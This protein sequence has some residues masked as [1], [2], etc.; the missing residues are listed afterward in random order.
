MAQMGGREI[1]FRAADAVP[2]DHVRKSE[3]LKLKSGS[4]KR[5]STSKLLRV[6]GVKDISRR[7]W[8]MKL[9]G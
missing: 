6:I 1:G 5:I 7:A 8:E 3:G 4:G 2:L 9:H